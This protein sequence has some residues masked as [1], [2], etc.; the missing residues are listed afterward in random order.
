[1]I[2]LGLP[3]EVPVAGDADEVRQCWVVIHGGALL[4]SGDG[5]GWC[6]VR[7][8]RVGGKCRERAAGVS[9]F[10][11]DSRWPGRKAHVD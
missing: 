3:E 1:M 7:I 4:G 2:A 6:P 8:L 5:A 9:R 11:Y 10:G